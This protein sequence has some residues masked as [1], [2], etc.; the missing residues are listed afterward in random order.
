ML[1]LGAQKVK[2]ALPALENALASVDIA[3]P[4]ELKIVLLK[5]EPVL[6]T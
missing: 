5:V 2:P 1:M 4:M 6:I 3:D